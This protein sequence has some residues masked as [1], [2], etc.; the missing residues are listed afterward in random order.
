MKP[1]QSGNFAFVHIKRVNSTWNP[2]MDYENVLA[3]GPTSPQTIIRW[4]TVASHHTYENIKVSSKL[5]ERTQN[6][7]QTCYRLVYRAFLNINI[8][9]RRIYSELPTLLSSSESRA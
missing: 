5:K 2:R 8:I 9:N 3:W 4:C 6:M 7:R 1:K